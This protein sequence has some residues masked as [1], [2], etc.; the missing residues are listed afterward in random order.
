MTDAYDDPFDRPFTEEEEKEFA[1]M[2]IK[3]VKLR[4]SSI[5][6]KFNK[7]AVSNEEN[8]QEGSIEKLEEYQGAGNVRRFVAK[9]TS[10]KKK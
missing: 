5:Y 4:L 7:A 8:S 3:Y 1:K 6:G 10:T 2:T 9:L